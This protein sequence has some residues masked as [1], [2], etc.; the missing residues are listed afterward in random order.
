MDGFHERVVSRRL[1]RAARRGKAESGTKLLVLILI[2][3]LILIFGGVLISLGNAIRGWI[4][5]SGRDG[6]TNPRSGK[7]FAPSAIK[8][9]IAPGGRDPPARK[10]G[11]HLIFALLD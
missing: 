2:F 6:K 8:F 1:G 3:I 4:A 11:H 9:A 7:M 10:S 5:T